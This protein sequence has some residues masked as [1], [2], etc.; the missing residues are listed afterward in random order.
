M[1]LHPICAELGQ[2]R[3]S[4]K[5]IPM[6]FDI[7]FDFIELIQEVYLPPPQK[8]KKKNARGG[9]FLIWYE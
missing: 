7:F 1:Y 6:N 5:V 2:I 4:I 3:F 9:R 8:K